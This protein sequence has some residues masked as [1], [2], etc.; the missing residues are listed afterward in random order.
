LEHTRTAKRKRSLWRTLDCD[1]ASGVVQLLLR[2]IDSTTIVIRVR[3]GKG[4]ARGG[5]LLQVSYTG[6]DLPR[7]STVGELGFP[8]E[9]TIHVSSLLRSNPYADAWGLM[10]EIAAARSGQPAEAAPLGGT[11]RE[12]VRG[13]P[14]FS[15]FHATHLMLDNIYVCI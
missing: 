10:S 9:A 13:T 5:E 4:A 2:N 6:Q 8:Q 3:L 7:G 12:R 11:R 1:S 14:C 15:T